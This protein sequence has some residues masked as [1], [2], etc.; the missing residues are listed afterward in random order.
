L[1]RQHWI[2]LGGYV[3]LIVLLSFYH[4]MW[5]DEVR[6]LS[7]AIDSPSWGA[8][9]ADLRHEGHP[10]VWYSI[11]RAGYG[12]TH[13]NLVLPVAALAIAAAAAYVI[14]RFA[15]FPLWLRAL[16]VFGAFLG[17]ELSVVARNYGIG[18]LLL[19]A[20]CVLFRE[21]ERR[22]LLLA[23]A[24]ALLANT[25]VH[26]AI[27]SAIMLA[28][29]LTDLMDK[30]R[31][32]GLTSLWG[33]AGVAIVIAGIVIAWLTARPTPD[34][35]WGSTLS[36]LTL[37]KIARAIG[38]DP[39]KGLMGFSDANIAA[40]GE[41]PWRF[42]GVNSGLASRLIVDAALLWL[43][44][45]LRRNW[46][47]IAAIVAAILSFEIV[48]RTIYTAGPRHEGLLLFLLFAICWVTAGNDDTRVRA[49]T[50]GLLPLFALQALALPILVNRV[51]KYNESSSRSYAAFITANPGYRRAILMSE[52]DYFMEP[53]RYYVSNRIYS[54]RQEQFANRV[55]FGDKRANYLALWKL[56]DEAQRV[57]CQYRVPVLLAIGTRDFQANLSG[58]RSVAYRA[59]FAWTRDE[60]ARFNAVAR[61]VAVFP[62]A[63][64]DEVYEVFEL[65]C[66]DQGG[67]NY[68]SPDV[69]TDLTD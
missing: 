15:P 31:R 12:V 38:I 68:G 40:V 10:A 26:A 17:Y 43:L 35:V 23:F 48:F 11:L 9:L 16:A 61:R 28:L 34:M 44:W 2:L 65:T 63:T 29:W 59:T 4:E 24:L 53:L 62:R 50:R 60:R 46:K 69:D 47:A 1:K 6:A 32:A 42:T 56:Q 21:R 27:A 36:S 58:S 33:L 67:L 55:Y 52:P 66:V 30:K 20:G 8:M 3:A 13:S 19:M 51:I 18:V 64:T 45:S 22:P 54:A 5:R 37:S 14:L 41:Y 57:A 39:G 7:V 25:S 49:A